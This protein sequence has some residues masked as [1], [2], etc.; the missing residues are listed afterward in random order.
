[1]SGLV[2]DAEER[3]IEEPSRAT[4]DDAAALLAAAPSERF[5][6]TAHEFRNNDAKENRRRTAA[7]V[8]AV[9]NALRARRVDVSRI[10]FIGKGSE[11]EPIEMPSAIQRMLWS[12]I[13]LE[14]VR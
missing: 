3:L 4:L 12:R 13:D 14:K 8:D 5:R 9:R 11:A 7:R 6:I 10:E 2:F 1:M